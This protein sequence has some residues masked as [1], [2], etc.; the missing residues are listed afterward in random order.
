MA[1]CTTAN[2]AD[3]NAVDKRIF[4]VAISENPLDVWVC[5]FPGI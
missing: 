1:L 4:T 5:E 3:S 2:I